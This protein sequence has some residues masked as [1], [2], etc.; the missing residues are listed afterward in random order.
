MKQFLA[1]N[2]TITTI[3]LEKKAQSGNTSI[4][5]TNVSYNTT[6]TICGAY[7]DVSRCIVG[8]DKLN[9]IAS[10]ERKVTPA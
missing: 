7:A 6:T 3:H 2:E 1:Q 4:K 5:K 8:D 10:D 9:V